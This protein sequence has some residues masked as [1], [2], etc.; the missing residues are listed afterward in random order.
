MELSEVFKRV[1][2][3]AGILVLAGSLSAMGVYTPPIAI[4]YVLLVFLGIIVVMVKNG[5]VKCVEVEP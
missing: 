3:F 5:Y 1:A 4:S 2:I